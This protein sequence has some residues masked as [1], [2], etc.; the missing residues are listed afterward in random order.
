MKI[1]FRVYILENKSAIERKCA[2]DRNK[3]NLIKTVQ[4]ADCTCCP[5]YSDS[6]QKFKKRIA[7]PYLKKKHS[8]GVFKKMVA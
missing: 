3:Q 8:K 1:H 5:E 7:G 4:I 6:N 2:K